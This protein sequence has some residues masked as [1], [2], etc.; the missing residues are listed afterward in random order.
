[1]R[2]F[3]GLPLAPVLVDE[4]A[5][6]S[7]R[8][9]S[10]QDGLR[11]SEP[12]SWHITLQFLGSTAEEKYECIL[13]RLRE[14]RSPAVPIA[15]EGLGFFDRAG[16]FF[17]GVA[18]TPELIAIQQQVTLA[19]SPCGFIPETRPYHPHITLARTKSK[20]K[21]L[22]NLKAMI[23]RQPKFTGYVAEEFLLYESVSTPTGSLYEVRE[24]LSLSSQ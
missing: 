19:T 17:A 23:Q 20:A 1:M 12:A 24:R 9:R 3:V 14:V 2:L 7:M 10:S 15:L 16:I 11:W 4:L 6:I 22:E 13:A 5:A 8:W 18:L 21:A